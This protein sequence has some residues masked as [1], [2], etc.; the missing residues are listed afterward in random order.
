MCYNGT[1]LYTLFVDCPHTFINV[2][3]RCLAFVPLEKIYS[4]ALA[5]CQD[6]NNLGV[7]GKLLQI[8]TEQEQLN[9]EELFVENEIGM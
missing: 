5:Y 1:V 3:G 9:L 8:N 2:K 7:P 6:G 4:E